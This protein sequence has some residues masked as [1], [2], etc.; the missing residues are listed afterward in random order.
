MAL[1]ITY[2]FYFMGFQNA[3]ENLFHSLGNL[4]NGLWRSFGNMLREVLYRTC[5]HILE[6]NSKQQEK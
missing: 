5:Y 3:Y 6:Y 1:K 4:L 2:F